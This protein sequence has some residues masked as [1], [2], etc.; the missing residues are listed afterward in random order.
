MVKKELVKRDWRWRYD[1]QIGRLESWL[2]GCASVLD[3]G[4]GANSPVAMVAGIKRYGVDGFA[5]SVDKA[6]IGGKYENVICAELLEYLGAQNSRAFDAVVALDV[7]EHFDR[8]G[9]LRLMREMERVSA[10]KVIIATPN[11]FLPQAATE[12]HHQE[13]LSGWPASDFLANGYEV[14]GLYGLKVLRGQGHES[15]IPS[16]SLLAWIS[17]NTA[18]IA[19]NIPSLAAGLICQ[20][21]TEASQIGTRLRPGAV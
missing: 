19:E 13:H 2:E 7:I 3:V 9:G 15:R 6:R 11:G 18:R 12:N 10:K 21:C 17:W 1:S 8:E 5:E 20:K 16:S 14:K 4:C